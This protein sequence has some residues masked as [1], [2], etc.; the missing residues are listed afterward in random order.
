M[1]CEF[2]DKDIG[3]DP[4]AVWNHV[5]IVHIMKNKNWSMKTK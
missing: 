4:K 3:N 2:C 1:K 5:I